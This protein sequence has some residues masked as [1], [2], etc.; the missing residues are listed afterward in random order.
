MLSR[1]KWVYVN[2][3]HTF[4]YHEDTVLVAMYSSG[5]ELNDNVKDI[6]TE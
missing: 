4:R 6:W 1:K 5:V 3:F 2:V